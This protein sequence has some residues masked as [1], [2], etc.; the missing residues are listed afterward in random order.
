MLRNINTIP[1]GDAVIQDPVLEPYFIVSSTT[2]GYT[3]YERVSRGKDGKPYLRSVCY[4]S[5]FNHALKVIAK[6]K[7]STS[8]INQYNSIQE[9]IAQWNTIT[10]SIENATIMEL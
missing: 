2:G 4:P 6:E 3:V 1:A 10:K 8:G 5:T 9:Y 7:L